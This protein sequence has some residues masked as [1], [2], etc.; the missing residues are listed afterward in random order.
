VPRR[1]LGVSEFVQF[2]LGLGVGDRHG[3]EL[4]KVRHA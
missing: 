2:L 1:R 4:G 3:S